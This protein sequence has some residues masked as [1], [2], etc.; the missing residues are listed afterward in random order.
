ME[1]TQLQ[2]LLR[3]YARLSDPSMVKITNIQ[4]RLNLKEKVSPVFLKSRP[5]PFRVRIQVEE[6]IERLTQAGILEKVDHSEWATPIVPVIKKNGSIRI[7]GDYSVTL[8]PKLR[9]DEHPLPTPDELLAS[10]AGGKIFSK[11]DLLQAYLQLEIRPEDRELLTLNT[12]KGLY[13][14][15]RLMYGVA[16][17]PA[18]W[19]RTIESI[20]KDIPGVVVFLDDIRVAGS[21]VKDHLEKLRTV[22][23]RL[24]KYNI[25]I[26]AEKSE[27]FTKEINY[28]GYVINQDGIH[29]AQDKIDAIQNMSRPSNITELRSL[30]GMIHYYERFCPNLS[31]ILQNR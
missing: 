18:I 5:V 24:Q 9:V 17:A 7:C 4:A 2:A 15:T 1:N 20:L 6:E 10:M 31:T 8:N 29:K 30:L 22:F 13:R 12:H 23:D 3:E 25:R 28:C 21:S 26:N 19:Q 11:I 27:F 14:L 16:S